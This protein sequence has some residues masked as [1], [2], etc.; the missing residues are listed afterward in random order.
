MTCRLCVQNQ[1]SYCKEE[2]M[3]GLRERKQGT[4]EEVISVIHARDD[5][6]P[7]QCGNG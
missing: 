5:G 1:S 4:G 3:K 6:D 2:G 7:D